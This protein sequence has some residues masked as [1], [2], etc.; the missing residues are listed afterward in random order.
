MVQDVRKLTL[1]LVAVIG[2]AASGCR[3]PEADDVADEASDLDQTD[4]TP[5]SPPTPPAPPEAVL[6]PCDPALTLSAAAFTAPHGL[7]RLQATGGSGEHRFALATDGSG[8]QV[9]AGTGAYAAGAVAGTQDVVEVTDARCTGSA[10]ATIDVVAP[11]AVSPREAHLRPGTALRLT[12][13]GG[14]GAAACTLAAD[15]TGATVGAD[16]TYRAGGAPGTDTV[17]VTEPVTGETLDVWIDV[18]ASGGLAVAG[19]RGGVFVP[20]GSSY[21]F[22]PLGGSG[23]LELTVLDG[24]LQLAGDTVTGPPGARGLV[25]LRDRATDE[26]VEVPVEVLRALRPDAPRD[27]ERSSEGTM[28]ALGDKDGDGW[29]DVAVG[30][31]EW[32]VQAH[33]GGAV[34]IYAGGRGG[35]S[36]TPVQVLSGAHELDT[37]GRGLAVGDVD[38]DGEPDLIV[39]VDR[40]DVGATNSGEVR[41][42]RGL[43]G[44]WFEPEPSRRWHGE[45]SFERL[46]SAL[47]VCDFDGD[48]W[49]DLAAGALESTDRTVGVPAEDQGGVYVYRGS[50]DGWAE[51]PDFILHGVVEGPGG[52]TAKAGLE[53][54]AS[55]AAGDFDDDGLCDLAA[56]GVEA[57]AWAGGSTDGV[58]LVY[59]GTRQDGLLLERSPTVALAGPKGSHA[60]LGHALA[61]GD[62]DDDGEDELVVGAW[63][64]DERVDAGGAVL[65]FEDVLATPGTLGPADAAWVAYGGKASDYLGAAVDVADV[66][67][68]GRLDLVASAYRAEDDLYGQGLVYAWTDA[69]AQVALPFRHDASQDPPDRIWGG[70]DRYDRFGQALAVVG[71]LTDDGDAE[72]VSLAGYSSL[73]GVEAGAVYAVDGASGTLTALIDPGVEA[74]HD[75]GRSVALLDVD[76][77]DGADVVVGTPSAGDPD[78]G[79]NAGTVSAWRWTGSSLAATAD[80]RFADHTTHSG[81]DR[82]GHVVGAAGDVDGDGWQDAFVVGRSDSRPTSWDDAIANPGACGGYRSSAGSLR[83]YRGGAGGLADSPAFAWFGPESSGY[84]EVAAGGF[85]HDGDGHDDLVVG[86]T[87]W[88]T[89]GG[90][91]IVRGAA[92]STSG[93]TVICTQERY[94]SST[95]FDRLGA[96]VAVLGDLDDDGCDEVAVG[97]T[98]EELGRDWFNQG[99][100]RVLWG[101]GGPGCPTGP[102]VT[103]LAV[104]VVGTGLG[105]ALAGGRDVDGDGVPDLVVGGAEY[106]VDFAELGV[107]WLVSGAYVRDLPRQS[108]AG[109]LPSDEATTWHL[110]LPDQGLT[111]RTGLV[112]VDAG[113]LFGAAVALLPHPDLPGG[114]LVAVGTPRGAGGGHALGGRVELF[115]H[116]GTGGLDPVPW[117]VVGGESAGPGALGSALAGG[118]VG[119]AAA[120]AVGAPDSDLDGM[121]AGAAYLVRWP[122]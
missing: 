49:L 100:V 68:D 88:G 94:T 119:G 42:H 60:E 85:D 17:R 2:T 50:S 18:D 93:T 107:V 36:P 116:D 11:L 62:L 38:G 115:A 55:L 109:G 22:A 9:H 53:L 89:G 8:A 112:G 80:R 71:D 96:S 28:R 6:L 59:R 23:L 90:V 83:V 64:T 7:L 65:V 12:V 43:K 110:L 19:H 105:S 26:T 114:T 66:D 15:L 70:A 40:A 45:T 76:A 72:L 5:T 58:V 29:P 118:L 104:K 79:A 81:S 91:A 103:T 33:Q 74:G 101:W 95:S 98:G 52:W 67:G 57:S 87:S 47:A 1:G 73:V 48:G 32:S 35:P 44:G 86:S 24:D 56:A 106:R 34:A 25:R 20:E 30:F 99:T 69:G 21:R 78:A 61:V 77:R 113:A 97:A 75:H 54:G 121:D 13:T 4:L 16:C 10:T 39:G 84:V 37:A 51:R 14:T 82:F 102:E 108:L 27:G 111:V 120:L 3:E 63:S 92:A 41:L 31:V 46:G 117:A 122:R